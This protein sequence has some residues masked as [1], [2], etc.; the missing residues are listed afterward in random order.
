MEVEQEKQNDAKLTS[1][2]RCAVLAH[3]FALTMGSLYAQRVMKCAFV[4]AMLQDWNSPCRY[5]SSRRKHIP[6]LNYLLLWGQDPQRLNTAHNYM[7]V[8]GFAVGVST[9]AC[10]HSRRWLEKQSKSEFYRSVSVWAL[11]LH[12]KIQSVFC[13]THSMT[14]SDNLKS[15][16]TEVNSC[17]VVWKTT[18]RISLPCDLTV[19]SVR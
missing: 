3:M 7:K 2:I 5:T 1:T 9:I 19:W 16:F 10:N 17:R 8:H 11:W 4:L 12:F 14:H 13:V 6:H 15:W 18:L